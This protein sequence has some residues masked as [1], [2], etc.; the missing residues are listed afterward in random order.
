MDWWVV[1]I[2]TKPTHKAN[3]A[4]HE[5]ARAFSISEAQN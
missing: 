4:P 1:V 2:Q 3:L 5:V